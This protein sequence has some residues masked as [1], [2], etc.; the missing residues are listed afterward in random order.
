LLSAALVVLVAA[1]SGGSGS[2]GHRASPKAST[3]ASS[4]PPPT[5]DLSQPIPGGSLA[6]TPRPPLDNTGTDYVA[7]TRSLIGNFR[8][9]TENPNVAVI[10]D[11]YVPGTAEHDAGVQNVQ[12]L[13]D[14]GWRAADDGY[15]IVSI[16]PVSANPGA[17]S[18]RLS[19]SMDVER[20]VDSEGNQV[21]AGRPRNPRVKAWSVLLTSDES[22]RWRIADFA[23]AEGESVQL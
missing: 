10:S 2:D 9:V 14:R 15:F 3:P 8:W 17:V 4:A 13:V 7:I 16:Q 1:C 18:L 22:G 11:L 21:G 23:T 6:G 20:I 5:I 12:Y 19:D